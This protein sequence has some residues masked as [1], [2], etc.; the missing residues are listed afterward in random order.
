MKSNELTTTENQQKR[1][2]G[3]AASE[4]LLDNLVEVFGERSDKKGVQEDSDGTKH[5]S[6]K[7]VI[8]GKSKRKSWTSVRKRVVSIKEISKI[9]KRKGKR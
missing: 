9:H 7:K 8:K 3:E 4:V 2:F 1:H 6:S 5:K